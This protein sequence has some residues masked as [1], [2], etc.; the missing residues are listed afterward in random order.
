MF[1]NLP[2]NQQF[3]QYLFCSY[4]YY[5]EDISPMPDSHYDML[6]ETLLKNW[7]NI[8][9][10]HKSLITKSDLEAG[11]GYAIQYPTIVIGAARAWYRDMMGI[12]RYE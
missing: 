2:I 6:C 11:T 4:L 10:Y 1:D 12:K 9:H 8:T 3:K 5:K 7:D